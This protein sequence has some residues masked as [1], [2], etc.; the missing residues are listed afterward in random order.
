MK[1]K[2][3][4]R[5]VDVLAEGYLL[6]P[7][8]FGDLCNDTEKKLKQLLHEKRVLRNRAKKARRIAKSLEKQVIQTKKRLGKLR[9]NT[10]IPSKEIEYK[11]GY[12][13][14]EWLL[15]R[16]QIK[17]RDGFKCI[18]CDK[19]EDLHVHHLIYQYGFNVWEYEDKYL[20]TLCDV[21]HKQAHD[22]KPINEFY[23]KGP[24][25]KRYNIYSGLTIRKAKKKKVTVDTWI[26]P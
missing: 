25:L 5:R 3:Y 10:F 13:R 7:K 23:N 19:E 24:E 4:K 14:P 6:T 15:R 16:K 20:I 11:A 9:K 18:K 8:E 22:E 12:L 26:M 2:V 21:C 17:Q 1:E